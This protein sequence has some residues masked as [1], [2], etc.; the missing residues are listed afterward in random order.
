MCFSRTSPIFYVISQLFLCVILLILGCKKITKEEFNTSN[1]N[2]IEQVLEKME[3]VANSRGMIV[4]Y[5]F[6]NIE[7]KNYLD[8]IEP[9]SYSKKAYLF[10]N[11]EAKLVSDRYAITCRSK[12][13]SGVVK[14]CSTKA[15]VSATA[16]N[17]LYK[18]DCIEVCEVKITFIPSNLE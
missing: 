13:D 5:K 17:C 10:N 7:K 9:Q 8:Y 4:V 16:W 11:P 14:I 1:Q 6:K 2:K 12:K 15:C 3:S 18:K